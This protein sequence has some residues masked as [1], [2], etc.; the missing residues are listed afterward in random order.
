MTIIKPF[1]RT[2]A[3]FT[4]GAVSALTGCDGGTGPAGP[5]LT[6]EDADAIAGFVSDVDFL[7]LGIMTLTTSAGTRSL[8]RTAPCPT[9]GSVSVS[10]SSESST[11]DQTKVVS[12]KW[13]TTQTHAACAISR[14]RG[15]QTMTSVV[16]G[17]VTTSG[18]SSLKLP[19]SRGALPTLLT[20]AS[21]TVGS[22]TTKVGDKTNTCVVDVKQTYDPVAKT[23][24]ISGVMCGRQVNVTRGL[25]R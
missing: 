22:T 5:D 15:D 16:N 1:R 2:L 21:A 11:N 20:W 4:I 3:L 24:T 10:G 18:S 14:T 8:S 9:G 7:T 12:T 19:E 17:S 23:F 6:V 13:S 25:D